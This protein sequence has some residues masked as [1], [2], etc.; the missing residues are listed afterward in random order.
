MSSVTVLCPNARRCTVKVTPGTLLKQVLEEACLKEGFELDAFYL[1]N[2]K[3]RVDLALPF[4]LSGLPNNATLEMVQASGAGAGAVATIALQVPLRVRMERQ[5]AVNESLWSM[6]QAFS[7][8]FG[9]NLT[10]S[11]GELVPCCFY[12]NRQYSGEEELQHVTLSSIGIVSGRCLIR[13]QRLQLTDE[14]K[15]EIAWR[16]A[17]DAAKKEALLSHYAQ[18]KTE[19]EVRE[20]LEATRLAQFEEEIR[21]ER[22]RK[23]A[24]QPQS[25]HSVPQSVAQPVTNPFVRDVL[26][27]PPRNQSG[28]S[29]DAPMFST[30]PESAGNDRLSNLNRLLHQVDTSLTTPSFQQS[31][32]ITNILADQGRVPLS[33]LAVEA[34]EEDTTNAIPA[35]SSVP[36]CDRQ[37]VIFFRE[38]EPDQVDSQLTEEFFEVG[39]DDLKSRQKELHEE[40][41]MLTQRALVPKVYISR[42]NREAKLDAYRHTVIRIPIG[43]ERL[44]QA[45]F[46]S[47]EPVSRLYEWVRSVLSRNVPFSLHLVLNEPVEDT[48]AKNFVDMDLAP[49]STVFLKLKD[50]KI[51]IDTLISQRL[52]ECTNEEANKLSADWL[53]VNTIFTPFVGVVVE[54]DRNGKRPASSVHATTSEFV[55]PPQKATPAPK[56]LKR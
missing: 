28:W 47:G 36:P 52:L 15:A 40:V 35:A 25:S 54:G 13:Y 38:V 53:S 6:L 44:I 21:L 45:N 4:R 24:E 49:K 34:M 23:Q 26:G 32:R 2:Q 17:E 51:N 37:S 7:E 50:S 48:D 10:A 43:Q 56:W 3:R 8:M 11:Q 31:E 41:Q 27:S 20:R 55:P 5:F 39:I 29:F 33:R 18:K 16:L 22:E 19:N 30:A 9:E 12:M 46:N 1:T 42:K 14:Q